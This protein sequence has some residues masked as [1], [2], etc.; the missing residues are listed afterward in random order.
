MSGPAV[1]PGVV[2]PTVAVQ[3]QT[4]PPAAPAAAGACPV[5]FNPLPQ[6]LLL[7]CGDLGFPLTPT[8]PQSRGT[9][10]VR[11]PE[12][13]SRMG[14]QTGG[15]ASGKVKTI[16]EAGPGGVLNSRGRSAP[17][18]RFRGRES[19]P[20]ARGL[21]PAAR[22]AGRRASAAVGGGAAGDP[23]PGLGRGQ[24]K[25]VSLSSVGATLRVRAGAFRRG[26]AA[27]GAPAGVWMNSGDSGPPCVTRRHGL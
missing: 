2:V 5:S 8:R 26:W 23:G 1:V 13:C 24:W 18:P 27:D 17:R 10:A 22:G 3:G 9:S 6:L 4:F 15:W 21:T 12:G 11:A 14:E 16:E 20:Q 19:R 25:R 7:G